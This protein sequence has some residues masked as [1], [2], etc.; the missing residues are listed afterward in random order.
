MRA[1]GKN[2]AADPFC[3]TRWQLQPSDAGQ[4]CD[5]TRREARAAAL[6]RCSSVALE[7]WK[8]VAVAA[9][10]AL[11]ASR[12]FAD[13]VPDPTRLPAQLSL[14]EALG[15]FRSRGLDL[16]ISE[17]QVRGAEGAVRSA[18]ASPNPAVST[19][20]ANAITYVANEAS[21]QSCRLN[22][23]SCSPWAFGVGLSDSSALS[24]LISGK[25]GLRLTVARNALAAAKL[26]RV[27]AE[28][29]LSLQVKTTYLLVAQ[30]TVSRRFAREV[31][32]TNLGT[33][34]RY[35]DRYTLGSI[36]EGD[37]QRVE[38][39]KLLADQAVD[40]AEQALRQARVA[41]AFLLGV[42]GEVPD[43]EV[44]TH[45]LDYAVPAALGDTSEEALLRTALERRPDLGSAGYLKQQAKA[46][47]D[48]VHRQR[49]PDVTLGLT[50]AWGGYGG[51]STNGPVQG[52]MVGVGL[53]FPFPVFY[54]LEGEVRQAQA[55]YDVST[56]QE[57]KLTAQVVSEV[58]A[59]LA[60]FRSARR[61]I[62]RLEGPRR[63][64]GGLLQSAKGALE[65]TAL[66]RE[67]GAADLTA[68]LDAL[69]TYIATRND[70]FNQLTNYWTAV[71]QL[72][73]AVA[74]ELR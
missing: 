28:R 67:K 32:E 18:G 62:E 33:L 41:L 50:Y 71:F 74:E 15:V 63:D 40:A 45:V 46:Q 58:G 13:E 23:A 70:Y 61:V 30:A 2:A 47:L 7:S 26:S 64:G 12:A 10:V 17:A 5:G 9:V 55:G 56:L 59:A 73:A 65:A 1:P 43:F 38:V 22:G 29:T 11:A 19:S 37:L 14:S 39:Q 35:Q 66:Q 25:R 49:I 20:A 42:R 21:Q 16:L 69:R 54:N 57:A 34:K 3:R 36:N 52:P 72:E 53:S 24:D 44:D 48:L 6:S 8:N 60:A 68:Y 27:D 31:A 4:N 51:F